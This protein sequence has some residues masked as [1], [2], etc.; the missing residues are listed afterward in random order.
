MIRLTVLWLAAACWEEVSILCV[1]EQLDTRPD[2][3]AAAAAAGETSWKGWLLTAAWSTV[4]WGGFSQRK[5]I[6][7]KVELLFLGTQAVET[8]TKQAQRSAG[9][10]WWCMVQDTSDT[11]TFSSPP[12]QHELLE[13]TEVWTCVFVTLHLFM[14]SAHSSPAF[15]QYRQDCLDSQHKAAP[16]YETWTS[17]CSVNTGGVNTAAQRWRIF[18]TTIVPCSINV[19]S[20][21]GRLT[22]F[23]ATEVIWLSQQLCWSEMCKYKLTFLSILCCLWVYFPQ[24]VFTNEYL[25]VY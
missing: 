13:D 15:R 14:L 9:W 8:L 1:S 7:G 19:Q 23:S 16:K 3:E 24:Y 5:K 21:S 20:I 10:W 2:S 12:C 22:R 11:T 25:N 6:K 4:L 18:E 17:L